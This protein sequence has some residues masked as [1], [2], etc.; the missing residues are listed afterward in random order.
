M[1]VKF[2]KEILPENTARL[3]KKLQK[4]D[5]LK[6]FYLSGGTALALQLGHRESEDLD[7]FCKNKFDPYLI[8]HNLR[9]IGIL[10]NTETELGTVNTFLKNVGL[11]FLHYPYKLLETTVDYDG[12]ALSSII[13]IACTK[14]L[15]VSSRGYKKDFIDLF[16]ILKQYSLADLFRKTSE[17]Y[18][19]I[20][21]SQTHILKSLVYFKEAD[22]QPMPKIHIKITWEKVKKTIILEVKNLDLS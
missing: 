15:T 14:L 13:D 4:L 5:F 7:F 10:E 18:Q 21:Y 11:Q 20:Q 16:F 17:K 2:Y 8:L 22:K 1:S 12:I 19:G 9:Q 3:L 6:S